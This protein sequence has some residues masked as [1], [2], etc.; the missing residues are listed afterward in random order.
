MPNITIHI[1]DDDFPIDAKDEEWLPV[2]AKKGWVILTKDKDIRHRKIELDAVLKN[3]A[4]LITYGRGDL[5]ADEMAKAFTA[6]V[7]RLRK[8]IARYHP[9]F[10]ARVSKSGDVQVL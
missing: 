5:S 7:P 4:Y 6:A 3:K 2:V 10:I 8:M 1:H 9:P